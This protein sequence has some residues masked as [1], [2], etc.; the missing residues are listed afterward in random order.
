E[1]GYQLYVRPG[2]VVFFLA[3]QQ[4]HKLEV[5]LKIPNAVQTVFTLWTDKLAMQSAKPS[6]Y[7]DF[8]IVEPDAEDKIEEGK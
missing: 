6:Q 2:D 3:N 8:Y 4:L 7:K 5:D 1:T